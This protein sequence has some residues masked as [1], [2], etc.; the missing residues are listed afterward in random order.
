MKAWALIVSAVGGLFHRRRM[1]DEIDEEL[2]SHIE[3]R[4]DD[5]ERQGHAREEARR[6]ARLEFGAYERLKEE[7]HDAAG[8][9][10]FRQRCRRPSLRASVAAQVSWLF[11]NRNSAAGFGH[12]R[13]DSRFQPCRCGAAETASVSGLG[14]NRYAMDCAAEGH[15]HWRIRQ[16]PLG[17]YAVSRIRERD[18]DLSLYWRVRK[19]EFQFDGSR[20]TGT[21]GR[22]ARVIG[23]LSRPRRAAGAGAHIHAGG[24]SARARARSAA[25]QC[26]VAGAFWRGRGDRRTRDRFEWSALCGGRHHACG[27][28]VSACQ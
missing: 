25:E 26:C 21:P 24:R 20:R 22:S 11:A 7:S 28:H 3:H 10:F 5:L 4:A 1:N 9:S 23:L 19:R 16:V 8:R 15:K 6:Q 17:P 13:I 2:R 27:V 14:R 18:A 12:W